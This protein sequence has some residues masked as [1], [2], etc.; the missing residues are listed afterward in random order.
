V[1]NTPVSPGGGVK[2]VFYHRAER[3]VLGEISCRGRQLE[4]RPGKSKPGRRGG[5][6]VERGGFLVKKGRTA[7]VGK[8]RKQGGRKRM[9]PQSEEPLH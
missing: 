1:G 3:V 9:E 4:F 8:N 7:K 2:R 6:K 5:M